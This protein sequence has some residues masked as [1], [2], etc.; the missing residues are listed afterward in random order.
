ML[1]EETVFEKLNQSYRE[2]LE[3]RE[4]ASVSVLLKIK[5]RE[6]G[7]SKQPLALKNQIEKQVSN[8]QQALMF[9]RTS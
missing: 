1:F 2:G 6:G 5:D 9:P 7:K 3:R 8:L 4:N